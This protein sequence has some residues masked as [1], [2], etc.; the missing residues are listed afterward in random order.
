MSSSPNSFDEFASALASEALTEAAENFFGRR[1]A[2]EKEEERIRQ[3]AVEL[4]K[5]AEEALDEAAVLAVVLLDPAEGVALF[6][7]LGVEMAPEEVHAFFCSLSCRPLKQSI[8]VP[9][10]MTKGGRF[11]KLFYEAYGQ[12]RHA[13]RNYLRG[14]LVQEHSR[15]P[16]RMSLHYDQLKDWCSDY[17]CRIKET[18]EG[19]SASCTLNFCKQFTGDTGKEALIGGGERLERTM[20]ESMALSP[21]EFD[22]LGLPLLPALPSRTKHRAKV[23]AFAKALYARRKAEADA[24][25]ATF[26]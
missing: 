2:L 5:L 19:Q 18:N 16:K 10:A 22:T 3:Q 13:F 25:L 14:R 11:H 1:V 17:N 8:K 7:A 9:K 24:L 6:E 21:L 20:D 23:Q 12:A 15:A 26:G 4:H